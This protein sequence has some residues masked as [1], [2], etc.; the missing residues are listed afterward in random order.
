LPAFDVPIGDGSGGVPLDRMILPEP[1]MM[2]ETGGEVARPVTLRLV[3]AEDQQPRPATALRCRMADLIA[4][5]QWVPSGWIEGLSAAWCPAPGRGPG[6]AEVLLLGPA[7]RLPSAADGQRFWGI[8]VLIP[9]GFRAEPPLAEPAL[10]A[11]AGAGANDLVV[12]EDEGPELIPRG[13]FGP[14]SRAAIRLAAAP[15]PATG[16]GPP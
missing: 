15:G 10:R 13:A 2:R 9:L 7:E 6:D 3:R 16:G 4:W 1:V 11:A 8:D 12:L 14:P 5:T